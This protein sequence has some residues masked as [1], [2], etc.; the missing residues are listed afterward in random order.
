MKHN[1]ALKT[2]SSVQVSLEMPVKLKVT[3]SAEYKTDV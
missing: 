2:T 1:L 3:Q